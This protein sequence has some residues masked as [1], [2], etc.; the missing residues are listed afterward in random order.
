LASAYVQLVNVGRRLE[1][2]VAAV[3]PPIQGA[4]RCCL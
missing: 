2:D 1:R 3:A 4:L